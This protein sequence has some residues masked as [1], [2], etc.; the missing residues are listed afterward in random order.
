[1]TPAQVN[2]AM[3]IIVPALC[4]HQPMRYRVH[5]GAVPTGR[6]GKRRGE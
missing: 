5:M 4:L 1:M 6:A 3:M 2:T